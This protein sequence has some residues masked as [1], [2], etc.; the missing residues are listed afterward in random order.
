MN[1]ILLFILAVLPGLLISYY[2]ISMDKYEEEPKLPMAISFILGGLITIPVYYA[3]KWCG[4]LNLQSS[5]NWWEILIMTM[6]FVG[7]IEEFFKYLVLM[8]YNYHRPYFNE[9]MDGI[10]YATLISMGFACVENL[11]YAGQYGIST[12]LVR[13]FTAVPAHACFAITMGY[14]IGK[15]KFAISPLSRNGYFLKGLFI[16]T[17]LH[18]LYDFFITQEYF[19]W[20]SAF[21]LILLVVLVYTSRKAIKQQ[22]VTSPFRTDP[23]S[24]LSVSELAQLDKLRFVRDEEMITLILERLTYICALENNWAEEYLD[25]QTGDIWLKYEVMSD[26]SGDISKRLI[27]LPDPDA[28][29]IISTV[30]STNYIDETIEAAHYLEAKG[31]STGEDY[32]DKLIS[33][34]EEINL[35]ELNDWQ[36]QRLLNLLNQTSLVDQNAPNRMSFGAVLRN[37]KDFV[38]YGN[39]SGRAQRLYDNVKNRLQDR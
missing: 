14:Y 4:T 24:E 17:F 11:L 13:F 7:L 22:Q 29:D 19:E 1:E 32:R 8:G 6:F 25:A 15:A 38:L 16:P 26:F 21:S 5:E 3:E 27:R 31:Q 9:P 36:K 12:T 35:D 23:Y 10:V 2:V 39:V 20:L 34:M 33:K 18:G 37:Q 28:G 30:L